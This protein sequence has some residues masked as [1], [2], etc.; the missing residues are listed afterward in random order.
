MNYCAKCEKEVRGNVAHCPVCGSELTEVKKGDSNEDENESGKDS[1]ENE[2]DRTSS[3][4][5]FSKP[6]AGVK[7]GVVFLIVVALVAA[8]VAVSGGYT[9]TPSPQSD[10]SDTPTGN[11]GTDRTVDGNGDTETA[12]VDAGTDGV[13]SPQTVNVTSITDGDTVDVRFSDG[14]TDEV[15]LLGVDTPEVH[16]SVSPGE[17]EGVP[18][19]S[20]G[21]RCLRKWG[22]KATSHVK[23]QLSGVSVEISYDEQEGRRGSYGRLLAYISHSNEE[24][25]KKLVEEGYARVYTDSSFVR[26]QEYLSAEKRAQEQKVGLWECTSIETT[27]ETDSDTTPSGLSVAQIHEDAAGAERDNLN[28]EY[29]ILENL[30]NSSLDL[31]GWTVSDDADHTYSFPN[32]FSLGPNDTVTIHTG[33]GSDTSSDLYWG[34]ESPVWNNG[35]DTI[36]VRDE[37]SNVVL[38]EGY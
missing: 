32:G 8:V 34:S 23:S 9:G 16:T 25:N 5:I 14:D 22:E 21:R 29:I 24:F 37:S 27:V 33:T 30:G 38:R 26:K 4:A 13:T 7:I 11:Q 17:F 28:D 2:S 20:Q 10:S 1:I 35:E 15:R 12:D 6:S 18:D 36:T 3:A 19:S 31:S